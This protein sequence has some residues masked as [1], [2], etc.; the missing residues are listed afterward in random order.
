MQDRERQLKAYAIALFFASFALIAIGI[1]AE[2]D[3]QHAKELVHDLDWT[4]CNSTNF[5]VD[6][7]TGQGFATV[8]I[9]TPQACI[10]HNLQLFHCQQDDLK[11]LRDNKNRFDNYAWSCIIHGSQPC[12]IPVWTDWPDVNKEYDGHNAAIVNFVFGSILFCIA[13][14]ITWCLCKDQGEYNPV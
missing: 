8:S 4:V 13:V 7:Q 9:Q 12:N 10:W 1:W 14:M 5:H 2:R 3:Y 11:C 6:D